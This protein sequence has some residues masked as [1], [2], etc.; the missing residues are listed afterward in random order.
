MLQ[1]AMEHTEEQKADLMHLRRFFF[2]QLGQLSR[3][4]KLLLS[5]M[6]GD[7]TLDFMTQ[8]HAS[9][10]LTEMTK[11][12]EQ[13]RDIASKEYRVYLQFCAAFYR[14]VSSECVA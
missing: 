1:E 12:S 10:R 6:L 14:G 5:K 3:D 11:W 8:S 7:N 9:D 13:L 2:S 4:R